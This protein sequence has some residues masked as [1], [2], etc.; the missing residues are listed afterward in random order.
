VFG[1]GWFVLFAVGAI[2]LQGEPP[3][4]DASLAEVRQFFSDNSTRFLIGDYLAG[5]AFLLL[6]LPFV[7][8]LRSLLGAAEGGPQIASRLMLVGGLATVLIGDTATVFQ[9]TLA[10][11]AANP[12]LQDTTLRAFLYANAA[13]IAAIGLPAAVFTF[14]ASVVIWTTAVLWRWL[15]V[16][17]VLAGVLLAVGAAFPLAGDPTGPLWTIRFISFIALGGLRGVGSHR[18]APACRAGRCDEHAP[19]QRIASS[20]ASPWLAPGQPGDGGWPCQ[21][22]GVARGRAAGAQV[23]AVAGAALLMWRELSRTISWGRSRAWASKRGFAIL[24]I[25]RSVARSASRWTGW[26]RL[27]SA[28]T[29]RDVMAESS[30]PTMAI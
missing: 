1:L 17:D 18:H 7:V 6:F 14:A 13:A 5:L 29:V 12:E 4:Y 25:N 22:G 28:G 26:C 9:D 10:L 16:L 2:V 27:V 21:G 20:L 3:A 24:A 23:A 30:Q 19:G 15:A 8:G 11:G